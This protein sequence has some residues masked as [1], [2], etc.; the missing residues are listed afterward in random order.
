MNS[1]III[2]VAVGGVVL[3]TA[4]LAANEYRKEINGPSYVSKNWTVSEIPSHWKNKITQVRLSNS[5][6]PSR[7]PKYRWTES[8][9]SRRTRIRNQDIDF[10]PNSDYEAIKHRP[11]RGWSG[12]K[13]KRKT[14][15]K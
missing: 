9:T 15:K 1:T 3:V 12:G 8:D 7:N 13:S 6:Y 2:P 10:D 4:L 11:S 14:M 5:G